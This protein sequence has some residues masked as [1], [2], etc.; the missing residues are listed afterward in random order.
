MGEML[1][2]RRGCPEGKET[3][4][5]LL[6]SVGHKV[7]GRDGGLIK[8][9]VPKGQCRVDSRGVWLAGWLEEIA[10]KLGLDGVTGRLPM[11]EMEVYGE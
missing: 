7:N 5:G 3:V 9:W 2:L 6:I 10:V 11:V 4:R 1:L 8:V